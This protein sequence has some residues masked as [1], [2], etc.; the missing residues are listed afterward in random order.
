MAAPPP[1]AAGAP[2][3]NAAPPNPLGY[4]PKTPAFI[5][6]QANAGFAHD[7]YRKTGNSIVNRNS[8][9]HIAGLRA[10][11]QPVAGAPPFQLAPPGSA[12]AKRQLQAAIEK[13]GTVGSGTGDFNAGLPTR[14]PLAADRIFAQDLMNAPLVRAQMSRINMSFV[15]RLGWVSGINRDLFYPCMAML[16]A[17]ASSVS[18]EIWAAICVLTTEL[19]D[20]DSTTTLWYWTNP[21]GGAG[22]VVSKVRFSGAIANAVFGNAMIKSDVS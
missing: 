11:T 16:V 1:P 13:R 14:R 4:P 3:A 6:T 15:K 18:C 5:S 8:V 20:L 19:Q 12:A 10:W 17:V 9:A 22:N 2:P 21:A 7:M